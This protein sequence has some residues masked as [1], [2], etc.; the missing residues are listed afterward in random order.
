[1]ARKFIQKAIKHPGELRHYAM[2]QGCMTSSGHV[3]LKCVGDHIQQIH[4]RKRRSH[5]MRALNLAR[6]LH[7]FRKLKNH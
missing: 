1:M 6:T 4:N 7:G 3:D 5:L 2:M